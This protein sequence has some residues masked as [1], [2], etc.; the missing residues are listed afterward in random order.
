[1]GEDG[2][3]TANPDVRQTTTE[4]Q[5]HMFTA[6]SDGDNIFDCSFMNSPSH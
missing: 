1:M 5:R 2:V 4:I 6:A 3:M